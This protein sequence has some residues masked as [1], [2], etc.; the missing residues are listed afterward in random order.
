MTAA[1]TTG[2]EARLDIPELGR[3]QEFYF[4]RGLADSTRRAYP[5]AQKKYSD[6]FSQWGLSVTPANEFTLCQ[7]SAHVAEG[8]IVY[9]T[10][11]CYLS[12]IIAWL[13]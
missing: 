2:A 13:G 9:I 3:A 10:V 6:F 7:F 4:H 5:S 12:A 8:G 11:K 1:C